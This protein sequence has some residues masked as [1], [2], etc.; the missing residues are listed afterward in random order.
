MTN[1]NDENISWK[2]YTRK[3]L[4]HVFSLREDQ[5]TRAVIDKRI[6]E[7]AR[8]TGTNMYILILAILIASIG[9][10]MD[11]TPV[12][13]GAMLISPLMS[14]II[15]I[16]D[17]IA[18]HDLEE[19]RVSL[20]RFLFQIS[21]S[22][23]TSW[24]YFLLSPM[25]VAS[26][27][28]MARTHPTFW[29]VL[30]AICGGFAAI[31]ANTR[32]S[33]VTNV[34]PGAAIATALM[35]PLCTVGYCLSTKSWSYALGA[36]YLFFINSTFIAMASVLGLYIMGLTR[37]DHL[38]KSKK[39][40]ISAIT[41]VAVIAIPSAFMGLESVRETT[42]QNNFDR[43]VEKEFVFDN[44]AVVKTNLG[45]DSKTINVA[46]IG[47]YVPEEKIK[48]IEMK[49]PLYK[50]DDYTIRVTQTQIEQGMSE[51]EVRNL[52]EQ[53]ENKIISSTE[54]QNERLEELQTLLDVQTAAKQ[55]RYKTIEELMVLYPQV[56]S[57]G[58]SEMLNEQ[59]ETVSGLVLVV[60]EKLDDQTLDILQRW[61]QAKFENNESDLQIV[62]VDVDSLKQMNQ[63]QDNKDKEPTNN[64]EV[65]GKT[66][67]E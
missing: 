33:T 31:I 45:R 46:L 6:D 11:S 17:A 41:I 10:N 25:S 12:V 22:I 4:R 60:N 15:A 1:K 8:V 23:I 18:N 58:F 32:K 13:I 44:T 53:E 20:K 34:I 55:Q 63:T 16:A 47:D 14:V 35:P 3:L 59:G 24:I 28:L 19:L 7:N 48:E 9:L 40:L 51:E 38:M 30:I 21:V 50:L 56:K 54:E 67:E 37:T 62:Q 5:A 29:D 43:Y 65:E 42:I 66:T 26:N 39:R 36:F 64:E 57:C 2:K 52:L 49:A 27:E 61:I